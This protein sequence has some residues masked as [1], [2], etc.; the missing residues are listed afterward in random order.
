[1]EEEENNNLGAD[2]IEY[3]LLLL[4]Q[5]D[6]CRKCLSNLQGDNSIGS[7]ISVWLEMSNLAI[8]TLEDM[9]CMFKDDE[10]GELSGSIKEMK[11]ALRKRFRD[12]LI[13]MHK[14]QMLINET[15]EDEV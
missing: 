6:E 2:K 5:V 15:E 14:K 11:K 12:C 1:M 10:A 8:S 4:M 13:L 9:L 7:G 3:R